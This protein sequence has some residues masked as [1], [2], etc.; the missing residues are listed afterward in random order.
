[1]D[2]NELYGWLL[3]LGVENGGAEGFSE[4]LLSLDVEAAVKEIM[5]NRYGQL[6]IATASLGTMMS[7]QLGADALARACLE[8]LVMFYLLGKEAGRKEA[9]FNNIVVGREQ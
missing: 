8:G 1:V 3:S 5:K 4:W 2:T 7:A 6:S 9:F